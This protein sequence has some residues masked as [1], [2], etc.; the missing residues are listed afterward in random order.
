[1]PRTHRAATLLPPLRWLRGYGHDDLAADAVAGLTVAVMLVPQAMAFAVLAG[2]PPVHGLYAAAVPVAVYALLGTS[3]QLAVG[4]AAI[5]CLLTASAVT[6]LADGDPARHAALAALLALLVGALHLTMGLVRLGG[7][8][9]LLAEPVISGFITAAGFVIAASQL[10]ALLGLAAGG[11]GFLGT[12]EVVAASLGEAHP[13]TIAVGALA[14]VALLAGRRGPA[15]LPVPLLV[16]VAATLATGLLGLDDRGVA[17]VG[18]VPGGL[19]APTLPPLDAA[20]A[21]ELLPA[22]LAI[23][24]VAYAESISLAKATAARTR[25]RID[26]NQELLASGA[27]NL[28]AGLL[29]AFPVAGSFSRTAVNVEAGARTQTASLVAAGGVA[30]TALVATPLFTHL[31]GAALAAIVVVAALGLVDVRSA[32]HAWRTDRGDGLMLTATVAA[33]LLVGV[34]EGL[35]V[36]VAVGVAVLVWRGARPHTAE[37]GRV[38]GTTVLRNIA[39]YPTRTDPRVAVLRV[40]GPLHFASASRVADLLRELSADRSDLEALVLDCSAMPSVDVTGA[41]ALTRAGEDLAD[42]GV[43]LHLAT[44]RGP[45]RDALRRA[46]SWPNLEGRVH[47]D[48]PTALDAVGVDPASP[49]RS[50]GPDEE[51]PAGVL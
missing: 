46:G 20:A 28:A 33:T 42:A 12:L 9:N 49:L 22:A 5:I 1:M 7:L 17:T 39:R 38:E 37:L 51:P 18:T 45:V 2:L 6:P 25:A 13:P 27:A 36:G 47:P 21:R 40:D 11:Q 29:R 23:A 3:A 19:P 34:E 41:G 10:P 44:V 43:V 4:P 35:A 30:L 15:R 16:L 24:L 8:V 14:V 48:V 26:P 31:P 32:A 50:P